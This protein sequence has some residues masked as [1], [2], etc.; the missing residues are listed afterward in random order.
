LDV[1]WRLSFPH[2][3]DGRDAGWVPTSYHPMFR[4]VRAEVYSARFGSDRGHM[5]DAEGRWLQPPPP[6]PAIRPDAPTLA[7]L[8]DLDDPSFGEPL[9]PAALL[10]HALLLP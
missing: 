4:L 8:L 6:W 3:P 1:W 2:L 10:Q 7:T 5:R 9:S